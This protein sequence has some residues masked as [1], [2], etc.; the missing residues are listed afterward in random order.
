MSPIAEM[1]TEL[2]IMYWHLHIL[3]T[4]ISLM[5]QSETARFFFR[6]FE[7]EEP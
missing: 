1:C 5:I 7:F 2:E 6:R 4:Y 3:R